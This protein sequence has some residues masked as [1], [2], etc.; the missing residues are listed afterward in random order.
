MRKFAF[1]I[2]FLA[3]LAGCSGHGSST[4]APG[5]AAQS[6]ARAPQSLGGVGT[7]SLTYNATY[8]TYSG[9]CNPNTLLL[10]TGSYA[11][12]NLSFPA[13]QG[14]QLYVANCNFTTP[15]YVRVTLG[16]PQYGYPYIRQDAYKTTVDAFGPAKVTATWTALGTSL[17]GTPGASGSVTF[18]IGSPVD[19]T[20][21][22]QTGAG[23]LG[24]YATP[25]PD[26]GQCASPAPVF[27]GNNV[28]MTVLRNTNNPTYPGGSTCYRNQV[29]PYDQY[30]NNNFQFT[31]GTH[32]TWH[33]QT[34]VTLN[35]NTV[36]GGH[37]GG[38]FAVDIPAIVWQTH[39]WGENPGTG[40]CDM[41]VIGNTRKLYNV[42]DMQWGV[43][44]EPGNP[45][46]S[47]RTCS[48]PSDGY[49]GGHIY[50]SSDYL[51]DGEVDNWQIDIDAQYDTHGGHVT[52][53]RNGTQVYD[54]SAAGIC[55]SAAV[56]CWWNFGPYM[57]YWET[58]YEPSNWNSA[59][60]TVQVNGMVLTTPTSGGGL[61][62]KRNPLTHRSP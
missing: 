20:T 50:N 40:P 12:Q 41:L 47:F 59:G 18:T 4:P 45:I 5:P 48:D 37:P 15:Q 32:Y 44:N 13:G 9:S 21:L 10:T 54:N 29:N 3:L 30:T 16:T 62:R 8:T 35:G 19:F 6:G 1:V 53:V 7:T 26:D 39:S 61:S 24:Q 34:V 22:W 58:S 57:F 23:S 55:D 17:P 11:V 25:S 52:A 46:W 27:S 60:S 56:G 51:Y 49:S 28:S 31:M 2:M 42:G 43:V 36:Y 33:F 38:G 14:P